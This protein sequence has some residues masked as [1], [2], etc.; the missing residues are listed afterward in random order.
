MLTFITSVRHPHN[1][2]SY[3][4]VVELLDRTLDSVCRQTDGDFHVLVVCNE[5]PE[6]PE[7]ENVSFVKVDF[8][9]PTRSEGAVTGLDAIRIDRGTKY[10]VGLL[11][12]AELEPSHVMFFDADDYLSCRLAEH[13]N[14]SPDANGWVIDKGYMYREGSYFIQELSAFHRWNGSC[15]ILAFRLLNVPTDVSPTVTQEEIEDMLDPFFL[16]GIL[17]AHPFTLNYYDVLGSPLERLPFRGAI[18]VTGTGENHSGYTS[19]SGQ[20]RLDADIEAEFGIEA[21]QLD[22][23]RYLGERVE[24]FATT[25]RFVPKVLKRRPQE[26]AG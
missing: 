10:F 4:R 9:P 21:P 15:N 16:R 26:A 20:R 24:H 3:E 23:R 7:R 8:P 18:Y 25:S 22:V 17:G 14:A 11:R 13:V 2:N 6:L 12:A 5:V 1:S 19:S